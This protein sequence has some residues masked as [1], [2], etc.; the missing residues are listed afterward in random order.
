MKDREVAFRLLQRIERQGEFAAPLLA[1]QSGSVRETVLG[2]LRWRSRLDEI[3]AHLANRPARKIDQRV[4]QILRSAIYEL[5]FM[6]SPG[7]AV[8]NDAV[9]LAAR[10][11]NRSRGFVNAVLRKAAQS[12]LGKV[13]SAHRADEL[14]HPRWLLEKWT[15]FFGEERALAIARANQQPSRADLLIN[16]S[17]ISI[18]EAERILRDRGLASS[19]SELVSNVLRLHGSSVGLRDGIEAGLFH[20]MDEGSALVASLIGRDS[21][22]VL[23]A[24]AA[25]GGKSLVLG[26][27]GH[28]VVAGDISASRLRLVQRAVRRMGQSHRIVA[29]DATR[30]PYRQRFDAVLLDAPCSGTGTIRKNPEIKWRLDPNCFQQFAAKQRELLAALLPLTERELIYS[31]CSLEPEENDEVISTILSERSDFERVD[32]SDLLGPAARLWV[33]NGVLRL[34]P[35]SGADGFT[36]FLLRRT[37][38]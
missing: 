26:L 14:A 18:S 31:T 22:I 28:G 20:P 12:D 38:K 1:G 19:P 4:L 21:R 27:A 8:V 6:S 24:A 36:A 29:G 2:V 13:P 33:T 7:Y 5:M 23:D 3:I 17:E 34:T 9:S 11:A 15:R 30:P 25:P 35:E 32:P 37:R 16:T 10:Q